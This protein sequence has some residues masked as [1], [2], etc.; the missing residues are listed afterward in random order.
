MDFERVMRALEHKGYH[1]Y[2]AKDCVQAK[3]IVLDQLLDGV[4][5]LGKGG[6]T[7][8]RESGIWDALV[9]RDARTD[10]KHITLYATTLYK[11]QGKDPAE[12]LRQG[13]T[14]DAYICSVN[15][16]AE[17]GTII[18][19]DGIGNRV[20]AMIY[21]PQ[22]VIFVVGKNKVF[23]TFDNAWDHL[24]NVTCPYHVKKNGGSAPC[25]KTGRCMHCSSSHMECKVTSVL[26]Y[27]LPDREYH[28]VLV[29]E[30]LGY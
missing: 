22:K 23:D 29:D 24:K 20:G 5:T 14:A 30:T 26:S 3:E 9:E 16:M 13:M 10:E 12:A 4:K 25:A 2:F 6:S 17:D 27:A 8:L 15:A 21:G 1:A 11:A 28:V 19:I 18:N 7:T